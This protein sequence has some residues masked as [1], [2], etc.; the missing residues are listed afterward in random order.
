MEVST[1][2]QLNESPTSRDQNQRL[3]IGPIAMIDLCVG[4]LKYDAFLFRLF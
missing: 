3:E 2:V 4:L 1:G